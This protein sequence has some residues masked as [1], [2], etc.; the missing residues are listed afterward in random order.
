MLRASA[1]GLRLLIEFGIRLDYTPTRSEGL[2]FLLLYE[3]KKSKLWCSFLLL[4][5]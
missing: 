1:L 5:K 3:I 2:S 4:A